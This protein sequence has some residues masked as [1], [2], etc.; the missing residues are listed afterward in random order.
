MRKKEKSILNDFDLDAIKAGTKTSIYAKKILKHPITK[1]I[2]VTV[3]IYVLL[4][5]CLNIL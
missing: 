1:V 5:M 4:Y 2:I 3:S